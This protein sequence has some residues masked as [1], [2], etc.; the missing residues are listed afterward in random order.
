MESR[1]VPKFSIH[2]SRLEKGVEFT[3]SNLSLA[4]FIPKDGGRDIE[5]A[6]QT[7]LL[8]EVRHEY[9]DTCGGTVVIESLLEI[10][11]SFWYIVTSDGNKIGI[12]PLVFHLL[13]AYAYLVG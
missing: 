2:N 1:R 10:L 3:Y 12:R 11:G 9:E 5:S 8:R 4:N 13:P 6:P 7:K